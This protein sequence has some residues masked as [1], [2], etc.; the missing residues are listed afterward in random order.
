MS[1][2]LLS[3]RAAL[4]YGLA[5]VLLVAL[6]GVYGFFDPRR[7]FEGYLTAFLFWTQIALGSLGLLFI[8]YLTGGRWGMTVTRLLEAGAM[9]LPLCGVLFLPLFAGLPWLFPWVHPQGARLQHLVAEKALYL[10][11]PFLVVRFLIYFV[12]LG[13]LALRFRRLS[14]WRDDGYAP[15]R[16]AMGFWSGPCLI[17]FVLCTN[18]MAV[19]WVMAL[20]PEWYSSM[21]AVNFGAEEGVVTMAWCILILRALQ[22]VEPMKSALNQKVVHDVGNLL[23]ALTLF[24]TYTTFAE[25]IITWTGDLPHTVSWFTDRSSLGWKWYAVFLVL[26]HFAVPLFSLIL[27]SVS[28][29]LERLARVAGLMLLAHLAQVVWWV[30][31]AFGLHVHLAWTSPVLLVGLGAIWL[32][33]F[34]RH[35]RAAPLLPGDLPPVPEAADDHAPPRGEVVK[36]QGHVPAAAPIGAHEGDGL[37][38]KVILRVAAILAIMIVGLVLGALLAFHLYEKQYPHRTSEAAPIEAFA[39]LPPAP[40]VQATPLQDFQQVN[41][42]ENAH[43]TGYAWVD[44]SKGIARLPIE[45]AMM[46]WVEL[47]NSPAAG[48]PISSPPGGAMPLSPLFIAPKGNAPVTAQPAKSA[49]VPSPSSTSSGPTEL[50]MRRQ[51]AAGGTHAP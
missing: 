2:L 47:Q 36:I 3:P 1:A 5:G 19:D 50:Q 7:F 11:I 30:Q 27:T 4:K 48:Q 25:Y 39:G 16:A 35:L 10:N 15:A 23:L 41:A 34:A 51:K 33:G 38:L 42:A 18:F 37:D 9:T 46:R 20:K 29:N 49:A 28:K 40:R 45:R 8:Q 13:A 14:L 26:V 32:A 24:W 17:V 6:C 44:R 22:S 12:V 21:L 31:P 43:L